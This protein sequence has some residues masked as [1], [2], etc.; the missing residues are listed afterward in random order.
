ML[1]LNS[2]LR[3]KLLKILKKKNNS[4]QFNCVRYGPN[5]LYLR[6]K[7]RVLSSPLIMGLS[8]ILIKFDYGIVIFFN[9]DSLFWLVTA[10][11]GEHLGRGWTVCFIRLTMDGKK[12]CWLLII[13]PRSKCSFCHILSFFRGPIKKI[14][15][16]QRQTKNR[17]KN[18]PELKPSFPTFAS[19][20][21]GY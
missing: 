9:I 15:F 12:H 11:C 4:Y 18:S 19:V 17:L 6:R 16:S 20:W 7:M 13:K 8:E 10:H 1:V 14:I 5:I 21:N 2:I 3:K